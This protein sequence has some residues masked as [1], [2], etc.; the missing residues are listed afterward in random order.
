MKGAFL[1]VPVTCC[2]SLFAQTP[3]SNKDLEKGVAHLEKE[4]FPQALVYLDKGVNAEPLSAVGYVKRA[5][6][7]RKLGNYGQ[8]IQDATFAIYLEPENAEGYNVRGATYAI[9]GAYQEAQTDLARAIEIKPELLSARNNRGALSYLQGD[10]IEA[11]EDYNYIIKR[12][13][14]DHYAWSN[15]GLINKEQKRYM[16]ALNDLEQA[17]F[18][19]PENHQYLS[20][21]GIV[22]YFLAQYIAGIDDLTLSIINNNK[23]DPYEKTDDAEAFFYRGLSWYQLANYERACKDLSIASIMGYSDAMKYLSRYSCKPVEEAEDRTVALLP[24]NGTPTSEVRI[25]IAPNPF[26]ESAVVHVDG[27]IGKHAVLVLMDVL[28]RQVRTY[29]TVV[30]TVTLQREE[31][32]DGVY[33][34]ELREAGRT[35]DQ[36][37]FVIN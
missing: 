4:N 6:A 33:L 8:A 32:P 9:L 12:S 13:P 30:R 7:N 11:M 17:L 21:Q 16:L 3:I 23:V 34:Y 31:L 22:R 5:Y 26:H 28:G 1:I 19:D 35:I 15:R 14:E 18:L 10:P 24:E 20:A 29:A 36:G 37:K 27:D 2:A 25:T